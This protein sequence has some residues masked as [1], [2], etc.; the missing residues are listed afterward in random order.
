MILLEVHRYR[1]F[2]CRLA[3]LIPLDYADRRVYLDL[4]S[5]GYNGSLGWFK[6]TYPNA[7]SFQL[8]VCVMVIKKSRQLQDAPG[9]GW[10]EGQRGVQL[11]GACQGEI[12]SLPADHGSKNPRASGKFSH[13]V[14]GLYS[15]GFPPTD[16]TTDL[17]PQVA[18]S[19]TSHCRKFTGRLS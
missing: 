9:G 7:S 10:G 18:R 15:N 13:T 2:L 6:E 8:K 1:Y 3:A 11:G 14:G 12:H 17:A 5:T 19:R 16:P 4:G